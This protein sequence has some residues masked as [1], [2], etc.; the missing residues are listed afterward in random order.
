M[1]DVLTAD[2]FT[3]TMAAYRT[4]H[5]AY[6]ARNANRG[7]WLFDRFATRLPERS[8]VLDAG[9]GPG[10]DLARLSRWGHLPVGL[11]L[12]PEFL[13]TAARHAPCVRA[14][15]RHIPFPDDTFDAVWACASLVHLEETGVERALA[16]FARVVAPGGVVCVSVKGD[17]VP[18]WRTCEVGRRWFD[19]WTPEALSAVAERAGLGVEAVELEAPWVNL[20]AVG[21]G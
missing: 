8:R 7:Q 3:R 15:V 1:S 16:E 18:G 21:R 6:T 17:G 2:P 10:R 12:C 9:C 11:D 13:A 5:A 20:W 14:D 4:G 19:V